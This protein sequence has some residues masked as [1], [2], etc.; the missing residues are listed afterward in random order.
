VKRSPFAGSA[1]PGPRFALVLAV[2]AIVGSGGVAYACGGGGGGGCGGSSWDNGGGCSGSLTIVW[3]T[4]DSAT[5]SVSPVKCTVSLTSSTLTITASKLLPGASCTFAAMLEN[6]G[7]VTGSLSESVGLTH[8]AGCTAFHYAD[9]LPSPPSN[10]IA[11]GHSLSFAGSL[12]LASSAAASCEGASASVK[13]TI[14]ATGSSSC[15]VERS[16]VLLPLWS[17]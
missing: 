14:T 11:S 8:S 6:T 4:P 7:S 12:S 13:V 10:Q 2:V 1:R 17:C 3:H 5:P 16:G 9:N 15:E